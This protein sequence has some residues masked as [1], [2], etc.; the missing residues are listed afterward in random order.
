VRIVIVNNFAYVTGGA[1][2]HCFALARAL[3]DRAHEVAF[4]STTGTTNEETQGEFVSC[5]VTNLT[6]D[7]LSAP[8]R[9]GVAAR[10]VWNP[11]AAAA[12]R[13]L[14]RSFRPDVVHLHKLYPQL[15]IAPAVL[16]A[17]AVPVVQ[18]LHD[19]E[20][21]AASPF[22]HDGG[23]VDRHENR[24]S[25]R[26]L[27]T[28]T[29]PLRRHVH[30]RLV[31]RFVAVSDTIA[32]SHAK[33]GLAATVL[34]NFAEAEGT[35]GSIASARDREGVLFAGRLSG[36]KGVGDV[37]ELARR[38]PDTSVTVAGDGPLADRVADEAVQLANLSFVGY[39]DRPALLE[40]MRSARLVVSPSRWQ[41]P[42]GL[43]AL[44]AMSVGTPVVGYDRGGL[45]EYVRR[46]QAGV[47]VEPDV[48]KLADACRD[49]QGDPQRWQQLSQAGPLAIAGPYSAERHVTRLEAVYREAIA[50]RGAT[51]GRSAQAPPV[52]ADA[53]D[54]HPEAPGRPA[55][56][57]R[58]GLR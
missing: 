52:G 49:L 47:L 40:R 4:L 22:D 19:Y 50:D 18:T 37:L 51:R 23:R 29:Y 45:A 35:E 43:V 53:G 12:L 44:E 14:L 54:P 2:H 10:A 6:R 56:V 42:G 39:L 33:R 57:P 15:S 13:R 30:A 9:L 46:A 21:V 25:Y 26:L 17:R 11:E 36:E 7:D 55:D 24:L 38:L 48:A 32:D 58:A 3:R 16:A 1:D 31:D 28:A 5:S 8:Q 34:P 41:E 27:N 20:L